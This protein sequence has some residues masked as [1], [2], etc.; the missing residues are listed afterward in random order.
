MAVDVG[1]TFTDA[2]ALDEETGAVRLVKLPS[3]PKHPQ[4][5]F[6]KSLAGIWEQGV[7]P[8]NVTSLVH[9]TTIGSNQLL[10]QEGLELPRCAFVVTKGFRDIL[11]IG[12]QNRPEVYN[13][14]FE[15][16]RQLVPRRWRFEVRERVDAEGRILEKATEAE[17]RALARKM[18]REQIECVAVCF[19]NSFV[20]A[21]NEIRTKS[22]LGREGLDVQISSEVDP[23][24]REYERAST[25]VVNVLLAPLFSRYLSEMEKSIRKAGIT[26]PLE[27]LTSAGGLVEASRV[28][29]RPIIAI[30]SGPA[31][32]VVGTAEVARILGLKKAISF[33]M[34]GTTAKAGT[35]VN[36]EV[37]MVSEIEVGGR[38]NRGRTVKGSGYPVRC[39]SVDLAEVSAGGGTI[40]GADPAEGVVV[41]PMSAGADPGPACYG[42]GGLSPTLT[43]ANLLLG[44]L[45]DSL[46]GGSFRLDREAAE[47]ALKEVGSKTGLS[48]L[49]L[50]ATA[51]RIINVQM[52]KAIDLV[53][54]E[55]GLDPRDFALVA[56]GGA[57]PMHAA[58]VA[59]EVHVDN[60]VVPPVPGLFSALGMLMTGHRYDEVVPKVGLIEEMSDEIESSFLAMEEALIERIHL[61]RGE[62]AR[63]ERSLDLRYYGQGYEINVKSPKPFKTETVL[64]LFRRMHMRTFGFLHKGKKVEVVALRL[65]VRTPNPNLDIGKI[66]SPSGVGHSRERSCWFEGGPRNTPVHQR[67][68][69]GKTPDLDGPAIVEEYD[70]T[71]VI[72]PN[73]Q[74]HW[75]RSGCLI[76]RRSRR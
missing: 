37:G 56:F 62:K 24:F 63:V 31:A 72:P 51:L 7:S 50:A 30:E 29:R 66:S 4:T 55:R 34:G 43:D 75:V 22:V 69:L 25:T 64:S 73:W 23:E 32:G 40:I 9:V 15:R 1:G 28:A 27:I 2:I 52:A 18:L 61:A 39:P 35:V 41:G 48:P 71:T 33:D 45:G 60:I 14:F 11:E 68:A 44:R 54:V 46:L 42:R 26:A 36:G 59:E 8:E 6:S 17:L 49:E 5:A 76:L 70:S 47:I 16:P 12:R 57:G 13:L 10:G 58:E 20:N 67:A 38:S 53:T 74:L 3:T 65:T 21:R 19:L